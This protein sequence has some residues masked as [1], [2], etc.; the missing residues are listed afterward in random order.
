MILDL[1]LPQV[2][3][4][5]LVL[6]IHGIVQLEPLGPNLQKRGLDRARAGCLI[7]D[8]LALGL[9]KLAN[10]S[11]AETTPRVSAQIRAPADT[12]AAVGGLD[13]AAAI[14]AI[15]KVPDEVEVGR[16]ATLAGA[17]CVGASGLAADSISESCACCVFAVAVWTRVLV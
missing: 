3:K 13:V 2:P 5:L 11:P 1:L 14:L 15:S 16:G 8:I 12:A 17:R 10:T 6:C 7:A 9:A 4:S